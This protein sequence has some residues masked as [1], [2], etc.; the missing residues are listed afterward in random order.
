MSKPNI[1]EICEALITDH[2]RRVQELAASQ[3]RAA[4][5][6]ARKKAAAER[7]A[8]RK[9]A[10]AEREAARKKAEEEKRRQ[11]ELKAQKEAADAAYASAVRRFHWM[12]RLGYL[13][14]IGAA[15]ACCANSDF[16]PKA[17]DEVPALSLV[18]VLALIVHFRLLANAMRYGLDGKDRDEQLQRSKSLWRIC[19]L[20][21]IAYCWLALGACEQ[22]AYV[23]GIE[24]ALMILQRV[25]SRKIYYSDRKNYISA[26]I[27]ANEGAKLKFLFLLPIAA[28]LIA[29]FC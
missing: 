29:S 9:K 13:V 11:R 23:F 27:T 7:E 6:A 18:T 20:G 14:F 5:E 1:D 15:I 12:R 4:E 2:L 25:I 16:M 17:E 24:V 19:L 22:A 21:A 3:K 8:A 26:P 28:A 10:E